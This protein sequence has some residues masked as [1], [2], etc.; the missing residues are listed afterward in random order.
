MNED[1]KLA[2]L[3]R[4]QFDKHMDLNPVIATI[5]GYK[6]EKYDHLLPD[7][8]LRAFE[9]NILL[10]MNQKLQLGTDIDYASLSEDGKLDL[11]LL[12]FFLDLQLFQSNELAFWRSGAPGL[13]GVGLIA[14]AIYFLYSREFAPLETRVKSIIGRLNATPRFL[15]ETKSTFQFPVKL[16]IETAIEEG[17]RTIGFL[18]LIL[19][20]L[21]PNLNE[22]LFQE[23]TKAIEV[24]SSAI[25][26]Y[27]DWL[28]TE[29]LPISSHHWEIGPQKFA[30]LV[31]LRRIGKTPEEI[32]QI[33]E[34]ALID[35]KKE[36]EKLTQEIF[37]DKTVEEVRETL[38]N[39]HPPT[40][41]MV[42]E[43][44]SDLNKEA[45][46]FVLKNE[47]MD[48][49]EGE[50]LQVLT[51]PSYLVPLLPF[52]AY[53]SPEKFS[54]DQTGIYIVT[55]T[56]GRDEMLKEHSYASCK[57]TAVHEGYPGH[58]VQ[59][60]AANLQ[61]SL[62]R[63]IVQGEETVEGWAHYCEQLMAEKGFL[64]KKE[65]FI[66]LLDQLWRAVR[67]IVDIK[68][69]TSQMTFD[70]AKDFMIT[71][72]GMNEQAVLAELKRYTFTPGYQFSY[73]LGKFMILELRDE[74][75]QKMGSLYSDRFFHN[76]ILES[77]GIPI[78]FLRRLFNIRIAEL[79]LNGT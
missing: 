50:R 69:H 70:E 31:E 40:F 64:G 73:L 39:D 68:L 53:I 78:E 55:P 74:V 43:H 65:I 17:A 14:Q 11:D 54:K 62:I 21:K 4:Q 66:Q 75:K 32:L 24:A 28:T 72:I 20:T 58:H 33:G 15:E 7:G 35:T 30:R 34:K 27:S 26:Q 42:L 2:A 57:N 67:I 13:S 76:T 23:L 61:P 38:K 44:I 10:T 79:Q 36:M 29:I 48:L 41:E 5:L 37:P 18:Q 51:T 6:H 52:A 25:Q 22:D 63:S 60:T 19:H 77:G 9:E 8:S 12:T 59:L 56:E 46:E 47:L 49:P 1:E 45:R 71:E 16:W 3:F